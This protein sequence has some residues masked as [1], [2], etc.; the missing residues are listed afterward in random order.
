MN[1]PTI[2]RNDLDKAR[3]VFEE[4]EPRDLF[5]KA[6]TE[7]VSL[8]L[9]GK[10]N[11][12]V[13]EG[14]ALLLQTWNKGYYQFRKFDDKHFEEIEHLLGKHLYII[15]TLRDRSILELSDDRYDV[16]ERIFRSFEHTL[17]PVGASKTLHLLAPQF[18]PL[19][20][21]TIAKVYG[22]SMKKTGENAEL[23]VKFM[24]CIKKQCAALCDKDPF[25]NRLLKFIDEYNYCKHSKG[26]M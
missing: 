10:T 25:D 16:I 9:D 24:H 21:R 5:Y 7:L 22:I 8:A 26:W 20:D 15:S 4:H 14:L 12:S 23:Y 18:F 6:A 17:G 19:W 13:A 1:V 3:R 2:T 11:L